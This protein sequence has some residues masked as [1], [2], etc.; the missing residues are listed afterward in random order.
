M[1]IHFDQGLASSLPYADSSFDRVVSSLVFHHLSRD[2]KRAALAEI[3]R[4]LR[5]SGELHLLD[6]GWPS[7]RIMAAVS[8]L[9]S[10]FGSRY[11]IRDNFRGLLP[12]LIQEA[13]LS[14]VEQLASF[15]TIFGTLRL[16][17]AARS[18]IQTSS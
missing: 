3:R 14:K 8:W 17:R 13:G 12:S 6:F 16:H 9:V 2:G 18:S 15:D 1:V 4:V 10:L 7:N 11:S 5:R